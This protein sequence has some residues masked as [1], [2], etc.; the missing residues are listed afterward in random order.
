MESPSTSETAAG[1][2][3]EADP[4]ADHGPAV[5]CDIRLNFLSLHS[6]YNKCHPEIQVFLNKIF[7]Y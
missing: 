5:S 1:A 6:T 3:A 4:V 7:T 2:E